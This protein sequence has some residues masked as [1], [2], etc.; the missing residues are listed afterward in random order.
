MR[1]ITRRL[2]GQKAKYLSYILYQIDARLNHTIF[3]DIRIKRLHSCINQQELSLKLIWYHVT[4]CY[5]S[6][7]MFNLPAYEQYQNSGI[8]PTS[9]LA[10]KFFT[11]FLKPGGNWGRYVLWYT[12]AKNREYTRMFNVC[13]FLYRLMRRD[14]RTVDG[15]DFDRLI[16]C[17]GDVIETGARAVWENHFE[18]YLDKRHES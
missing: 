2:L 1:K 10:T 9:G 13:W 11:S 17:H 18:W 4:V 14:L 15:W 6:W 12:M 3:R 8:S 5:V 7:K 16:P